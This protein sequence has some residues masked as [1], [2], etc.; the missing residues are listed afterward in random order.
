MEQ[1]LTTLSREVGERLRARG[2]Q[3]TCAESCTG[4]LIAKLLTDIAGSS[5]YFERGFVTYSNRAKEEMLGVAGGVLAQHGA[6][7]E[8][9][10]AAMAVGALRAARADLAVA[11]S[12]IAGPDG[13]SAQKPVGTVWFGF[14]ARGGE[15]LCLCRHFTGD[16]DAV[17]RQ[18]A[19][20][21]LRTL[22]EKFLT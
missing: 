20:F 1:S 9:V 13:G 5:C 3:V 18:A 8:P 19:Q 12:G 11:V 7:S 16:R 17:R 21:A 10:A 22:L 2:E 14:A 15:P 6:V 4:G